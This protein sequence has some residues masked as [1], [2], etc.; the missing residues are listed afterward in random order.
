M[1]SRIFLWGISRN[2][3]VYR[4]DRVGEEKGR[5]QDKTRRA[6]A[7]GEEAQKRGDIRG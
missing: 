2:T 4:R 1:V 3:R 5:R 7:L 6:V